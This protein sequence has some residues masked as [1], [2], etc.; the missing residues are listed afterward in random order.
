MAS[1]YG[2]W[3]V[4]ALLVT[5]CAAPTAE[6]DEAPVAEDELAKKSCKLFVEEPSIRYVRSDGL[7]LDNPSNPV[8][9]RVLD[10][11]VQNGFVL[12][13]E[14]AAATLTMETEV[15][16]GPTQSWV[17]FTPITQ[18]ACQT[19]VRFTKRAGGQ[20]LNRS[21]TVAKPGLAIDFDGITWPTCK[22][23]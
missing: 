20:V 2:T 22:D 16:C 3:I 5:A 7:V 9:A 1:S 6:P 21:R 13:K 14:R 18:D 12:A 11:L 17:W 19:E 4:G 23:L 15:R 10:R 8:N